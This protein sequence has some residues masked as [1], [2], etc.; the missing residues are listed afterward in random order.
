ME[1]LLDRLTVTDGIFLTDLSAQIGGSP[2]SGDFRGLVGGS[3][4]VTGSILAEP[5][6]MS[7]RM[8]SDDGGAVL[9]A[10][11]IY[12]NAYGGAFD[13]ILRPHP[14][15]GNYAG[16]MTIDNPRLRNAPA[17]AELLNLVSVVGLIE[18]MA[19]GEGVSLGEV[20]ADFRI[21][22]GAITIVEGTAIGPSMGLS[23]DG[24][25]DTQAET[26]D[27]QGVVSPLYLVNGLVG[28]LFTPRREGLFGFTYRMRGAPD[29]STVTV[30]PLSV[31]TPGIFR[32]IFRSPPPEPAQ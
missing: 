7:L 14:G 23:L 6:G 22:P 5:N 19:S 16:L 8:Q 18:Q 30:N 1:I 4:Y 12:Y 27:F 9:R 29:N 13:L 15:Q 2:I 26:V 31:L 3:A 28:A 21:S 10:G 25:Y 17:F 24:V 20:R 32:E 11:G